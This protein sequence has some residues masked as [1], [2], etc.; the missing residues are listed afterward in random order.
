M[1]STRIPVGGYAVIKIISRNRVMRQIKLGVLP[2]QALAINYLIMVKIIECHRLGNSTG[3]SLRT[4]DL[5]TWRI[6]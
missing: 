1:V 3:Y 6:A 4:R 5:A 2:K